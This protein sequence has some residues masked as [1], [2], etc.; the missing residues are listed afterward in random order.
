MTRTSRTTGADPLHLALVF[1][2]P[3]TTASRYAGIAQ[4]L[5]DDRLSAVTESAETAAPTSTCGVGAGLG[6][7]TPR[8][9][10]RCRGEWRG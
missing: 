3:H 5:L 2:L 1:D 4:S 8:G 6:L 10:C 9:R 7:G